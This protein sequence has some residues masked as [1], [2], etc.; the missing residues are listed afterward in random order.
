MFSL[1]RR[2]KKK[3]VITVDCVIQEILDL[4]LFMNPFEKWMRFF[5]AHKNTFEYYV[6]AHD[7]RENR[8]SHHILI[9][10]ELDSSYNSTYYIKVSKEDYTHLYQNETIKKTK[11]QLL[12]ISTHYQM[13]D[14]EERRELDELFITALQKIQS[15]LKLESIDHFSSEKKDLVINILQEMDEIM[16]GKRVTEQQQGLNSLQDELFYLQRLKHANHGGR[17]TIPYEPEELVHRL[18]DK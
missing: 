1:F 11:G 14:E 7:Y 2:K 18:N 13:F 4:P 12:L 10:F 5:S 6:S 8:I 17:G 15:S 3:D 9:P 16:Q